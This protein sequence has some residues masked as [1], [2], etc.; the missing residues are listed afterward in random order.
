[1]IEMNTDAYRKKDALLSLA[2][3]VKH[4]ITKPI[5][6]REFKKGDQF[7]VCELMH[8]VSHGLE[9]FTVDGRPFDRHP[10]ST[11]PVLR[12]APMDLDDTIEIDTLLEWN[13]PVKELKYKLKEAQNEID[14]LQAIVNYRNR[15]AKQKELDAVAMKRFLDLPDATILKG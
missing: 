12:M 3:R 14:R 10:F 15:S 13:D 11:F 2:D 1:M 5:R 6:A 4:T 9:Q 7:V 8:V